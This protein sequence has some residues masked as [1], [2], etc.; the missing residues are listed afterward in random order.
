MSTTDTITTITVDMPRVCAGV[1]I[2][3]LALIKLSGTARYDGAS[4]VVRGLATPD[5][6]DLVRRVAAYAAIIGEDATSIDSHQ[7]AAQQSVR[8]SIRLDIAAL[9]IRGWGPAPWDE[10]TD[11]AERDLRADIC[12]ARIERRLCQH[13]GSHGPWYHVSLYTRGERRESWTRITH[14]GH[15]NKRTALAMGL[16][17]GRPISADA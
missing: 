10:L 5:D 8:E 7:R 3:Y 4:L 17:F 16:P 12:P 2:E 1:A 15:Y 14:Y 6:R 9:C 11:G 13:S